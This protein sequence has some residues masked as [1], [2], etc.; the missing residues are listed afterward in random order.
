[1]GCCNSAGENVGNP[2]SNPP[3]QTATG[4]KSVKVHDA[5]KLVNEA[6]SKAPGPQADSLNVLSSAKGKDSS[7]RR[8]FFLR[9]I[10]LTLNNLLFLSS[11]TRKT[12]SI[13]LRS[14]NTSGTHHR[15]QHV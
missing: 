2:T 7:P 9:R 3:K 8:D 6:A 1:M 4:K 11:S 5:S 10:Q 13:Q 12:S 14:K 15:P